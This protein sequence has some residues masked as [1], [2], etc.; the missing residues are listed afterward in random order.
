[1]A[2]RFYVNYPLAPGTV[3]VEGP[4]AHH[5]AGV[6]RVRPGDPVCLFNGDGH[7][8]PTQVLAVERRRVTLQVHGQASPAR[9]LP[10]AVEVAAPLPRGD[11]AQ[12]LLE[13]LTELGVVSFVPLQTRRSVVHPRAAKLEKLHRYVIEASKQCGRNVLLQVLPLTDWE[14][15]CRSDH[16]AGARIVA[17]PGGSRIE[18]RGSKIEGGKALTSAASLDPRSSI[19]DPHLGV[20]LAVGPEGGF[21]EEEIIAA[22]DAGWRVHDL[23]P[24]ILR[25]ETAALVMAAWAALGFAGCQAAGSAPRSET[26]GPG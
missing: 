10:F 25:V 20:A 21:T 8:Y 1:M 7:E 6:C 11:R 13:K 9:E 12:F 23:G 2:E 22:Q 5:L 26:P 15:Y 19:L 16:L 14:T 4:E 3:V 17:H 18:D 24:R